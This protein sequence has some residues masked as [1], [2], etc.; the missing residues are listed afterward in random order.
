[1]QAGSHVWAWLHVSN[2]AMLAN[3]QVNCG[4]YMV[5]LAE[6]YEGAVEVAKGCPGLVGPRSSCEIRAI[7][8]S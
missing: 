2:S 5:V 3:H 8:S 1:M 4:G 7:M 6:N